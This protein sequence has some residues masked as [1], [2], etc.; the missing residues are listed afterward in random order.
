M[1]CRG[2]CPQP[3]STGLPIRSS[4]IQIRAHHVF[5]HQRDKA[6]AGIRFPHWLSICHSRRPRASLYLS[7]HP[8]TSRSI[9]IA[10]TLI[11]FS[12]QVELILVRTISIMSAEEDQQSQ[13]GYEDGLAGGPGAPTPLS[14]LEV[15]FSSMSSHQV[16]L[17]FAIGRLWS[18]EA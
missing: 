8:R 5:S 10:Y 9:T 13:S 1:H 11:C 4:P 17:T 15:R 18:L 6:E 7:L 16:C 3:G 12:F 14:A 2:C